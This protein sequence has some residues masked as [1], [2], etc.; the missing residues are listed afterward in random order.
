MSSSD[1]YPPPLEPYL[2]T[3]NVTSK[4]GSH[5][6]WLMV[7]YHV[8]YNFAAT[9]DWIRSASPDLELVINAGV[10]T[11]LYDGDADYICNYMG[12]EAMVRESCFSQPL[13]SDLCGDDA[14]IASLNASTSPLFAKQEF[15]NYTVNG[16]IAGLYKNA[17]TFSY[18][19]VFGAG[20]EVPAYLWRGVSRGAAAL[21]MFTQIMSDKPLSGT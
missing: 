15:A 7:N 4:I 17:G 12:V 21:Q 8:Y 20:H 13:L 9:G 5:H 3:T 19:R 14:Q 1:P 6:E 2:N 18:M 11:V 16:Q 10:R